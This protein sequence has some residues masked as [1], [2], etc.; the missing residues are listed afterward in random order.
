MDKVFLAGVASRE[1]LYVA[2]T[3]GR[4]SVRIFVTDR[5]DFLDAAGLR[6]EARTSALEFTRHR[7]LQP[8]FR[9]YLARAWNYALLLR[10]ELSVDET[11]CTIV[12]ATHEI[13][14][15]GRHLFGVH[16]VVSQG[17][18]A[19]IS[20]GDSARFTEGDKFLGPLVADIRIEPTDEPGRVRR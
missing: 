9:G 14:V 3:R 4:E 1:G 8:A 6:S 11:S 18:A 5:E 16:L 13:R 2:A 10:V 20:I 17:Q 12:F 7:S 19:Q 15:R